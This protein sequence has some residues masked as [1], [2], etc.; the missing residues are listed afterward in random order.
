MNVQPFSIGT[1]NTVQLACTGTSA[2][3]TLSSAGAANNGLRVY[4][5]GTVTAFIRAT[6][7]ASTASVSTDMPIPPGIVEILSKGQA[8]TITGITNG[9]SATLYL[10]PGEGT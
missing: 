2:S 3:V 9:G 4:N 10:T 6:S 1:G 5:S 8:D 7:G